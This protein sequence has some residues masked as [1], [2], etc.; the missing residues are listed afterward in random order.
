MMV[1]F[2]LAQRG[3]HLVVPLE[4]QRAQ[5][6][7]HGGLL[8]NQAREQRGAARGADGASPAALVPRRRAASEPGKQHRDALAETHVVARPVHA[9]QL[10]V[11]VPLGVVR[12]D[13]YAGH[14][15]ADFPPRVGVARERVSHQTRIP[16]GDV[17]LQRRALQHEREALH[18][19]AG[20]VEG[21]ARGRLSGVALRRTR[22]AELVHVAQ[23][24]RS[25]RRRV[26]GA[27][28][29]PPAIRHIGS[30]APPR[31]EPTRRAGGVPPRARGRREHARGRRDHFRPRVR[32]QAG[33]ASRVNDAN[34]TTSKSAK[35]ATIHERV[36]EKLRWIELSN[37]Q[38]E[39]KRRIAN[40]EIREET[41]GAQLFPSIGFK[42]DVSWTTKAGTRS[43][44]R[45]VGSL[46]NPQNESE[47]ASTLAKP[48]ANRR[49]SPQ[50]P[51][52]SA[53]DRHERNSRSS[54]RLPS[55]VK[56]LATARR[57]RAEKVRAR[58]LVRASPENRSRGTRQVAIGSKATRW[59]AI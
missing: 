9:R 49:R 28:A 58:A 18:E 24:D 33:R 44:T 5:D 38:T 32:C 45:G 17:R 43:R 47:F 12:A 41:S 25:P 50:R 19:R 42:I 7:A 48:P 40:R 21:D 4:S 14:A 23:R 15:A 34:A 57:Q 59:G 53:R 6:A 8:E 27:P 54:T 13:A 11:P 31:R 51:H 3:E 10:E 55:L 16:R 56:P 30:P 1:C 52:R 29:D 22:V 37:R 26:S 46:E 2:L 20:A 35:K 39:F 36:C